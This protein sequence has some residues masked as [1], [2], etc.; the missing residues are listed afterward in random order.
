M[1]HKNKKQITLV[2]AVAQNWTIGNQGKMAWDAPNELRHFRQVTAGGCLIFGRK[3]FSSLP[4]PLA[5]RSLI[6]VSKQADLPPNGCEVC[7]TFTAALV[8]AE[9]RP[10]NEIII[11][12]GEQIYVQAL[13]IADKVILSKFAFECEGDRF[14]PKFGSAQWPAEQWRLASS[15]DGLPGKSSYKIFEYLRTG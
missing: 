13:P 15:R 12:G 7:K 3:T 1:N 6:V 4:K 10:G 11:A 14:F 9:Q 8:A 5:G 2:V